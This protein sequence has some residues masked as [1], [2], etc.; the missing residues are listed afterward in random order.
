V[1]SLRIVSLD[2]PWVIDVMVAAD[3][4]L[5]GRIAKTKSGTGGGVQGVR[6]VD[7][8]KALQRE[9]QWP[10]NPSEWAMAGQVSGVASKSKGSKD[11]PQGRMTRALARRQAGGD[12]DDLVRRVDWL[13]RRRKFTG[14]VREEQ[15]MRV[16]SLP[17]RRTK[18]EEDVDVWVAKFATAE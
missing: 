1:R 17:G 16:G 18:G 12:R 8:W 15:T 5:D 7:V 6:V 9:L 11:E 13:G 14:L 10:V 3:D 4:D 2:F